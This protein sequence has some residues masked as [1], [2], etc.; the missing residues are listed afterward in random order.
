[1]RALHYCRIVCDSSMLSSAADHWSTAD[2][3]FKCNQLIQLILQFGRDLDCSDPQM[4]SGYVMGSLRYWE[5]QSSCLKVDHWP[6]NARSSVQICQ[7][8]RPLRSRGTLYTRMF[9]PNQSDPGNY[10]FFL[11]LLVCLL[12]LPL[13]V[14]SLL[15]AAF[16]TE[17]E[18]EGQEP[19]R[20]RKNIL[21]QCRILSDT[22]RGTC[23]GWKFCDN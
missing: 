11:R 16:A 9:N 2:I 13:L 20:R 12:V 8:P 3:G 6:L 17:E 4:C 18:P 21:L 10:H 15:F 1:M 23:D 7:L 19:G 14:S 22:T 5:Y